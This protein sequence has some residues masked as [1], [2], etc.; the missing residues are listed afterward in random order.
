MLVVRHLVGGDNLGDM[1]L[2]HLRSFSGDGHPGARGLLDGQ[3]GG[4]LG[5]RQ[6]GG[7]IDQVG[8]EHIVFGI[9]ILHHGDR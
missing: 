4:Q 3:H 8:C 5:Y 7:E 6:P 2:P 9:N 1:L